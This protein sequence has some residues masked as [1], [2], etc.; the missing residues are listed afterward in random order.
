MGVTCFIAVVCNQTH[1]ISEVYLYIWG[2]DI[3]FSPCQ[4]RM[5]PLKEQFLP[6]STL[7]LG[8]EGPVAS[9][10]LTLT[11][12]ILQLI[13]NKVIQLFIYNIHSFSDSF[14]Y[15]L[16]QFTEQSSLCHTVGPSVH[17]SHSVMSDSLSP[18]WTAACQA[19]L[20]IT[21]SRSSPKPVSI[22]SVMPS[23][24]LIL[25]HPLLSCLQSFPASGSFQMGWS[26]T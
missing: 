18:Q 10:F 16:L 15:S 11:F 5:T 4:R 23:N 1:S 2:W 6:V 7:C 20:S 21:N 14:P 3:Q 13:Y 17:F 24:H 19:S 12:L 8:D 9:F 25:C 22:E 26:F